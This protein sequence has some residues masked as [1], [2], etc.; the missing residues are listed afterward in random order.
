MES[1][2]KLA[3][4]GFSFIRRY[5][6]ALLAAAGAATLRV[7][8]IP[9]VGTKPPYITFYLGI[10]IAAAYGGVGPGL[11]TMFIGLVFGI[12][13]LHGGPVVIEQ[14]AVRFGLY[15]LSGFG[16]CFIAEAM[17]RQ[18]RIA[19]QQA[20]DLQ[21]AHDEL[22]RLVRERTEELRRKELLLEQ[23]SRQA[24]MG[25]MIDNIA[26]QWRQPL[27]TLGLIIQSLSMLHDRGQLSQGDLQGTEE[28][29]M[30][31]IGHMSQTINDFREYVKPDK[32]KVPFHASQVISR[33]M[34]LTEDYLKTFNVAIEVIAE[35]DPVILGYPNQFCQVL[36]N[37]LLNARDAAVARQV[38]P[39]K[40]FIT[41]GTE[42]GRAVITIA[43]N[44][45]G[46]PERILDKI[47]EPYFTTKG[48]EQGTGI[49][50]FMS[51]ALIEKMGGKLVAR[52]IENGAEFR[53]EM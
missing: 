53:I 17:H 13:V 18:R 34:K 49:G 47:F 3:T 23:Q 37:I 52:N 48:S 30:E 21:R 8:L 41:T 50:L 39:A 25:E 46:I 22:E 29:A 12:I 38:R 20:Q 43:D 40:I 26:H 33:T 9:L 32:E 16:I 5:G 4:A 27:N 35:V 51:K 45:G 36:L 10:V 28:K 42:A 31:I 6:I 1:D 24:A 44:A 7:V 2:K 14:E 19:Q 15:V 11:L